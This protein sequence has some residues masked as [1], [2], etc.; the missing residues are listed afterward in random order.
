VERCRALVN[1]LE[2]TGIPPGHLHVVGSLEQ[3]LKGLP[4]AT[5][6]QKSEL[7]HGLEIGIGIGATG[8]LLAWLLGR[9]LPPPG[10][11]IGNRVLLWSVLAGALFGGLVSALMKH[12]EH[13]HRLARY[14]QA[15]AAGRILLMV[16]VPR[17]EVER[18]R[19]RILSQHP[20][21]RIDVARKKKR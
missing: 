6:W 3:D 16:D 20:E 9:L 7:L 17:S 19:E 18:T 4:L 1:D 13:N 5:V 11:E 15:M 8:G 12:H 21:A 14:D 10:M 2:G